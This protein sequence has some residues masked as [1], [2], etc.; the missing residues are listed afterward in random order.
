MFLKEHILFTNHKGY[1][2]SLRRIIYTE[3][4][5]F[6][7]NRENSSINHTKKKCISQSLTQK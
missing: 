5:W 3:Q 4:G 2:D 6:S 1:K 7:T